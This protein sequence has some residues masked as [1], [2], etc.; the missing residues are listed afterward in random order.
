MNSRQKL[1]L[2]GEEIAGKFLI[3][4]GYTL[5]EKNFRTPYGEIDII[6]SNGSQLVFVEVKTRRSASYGAP[7]LA[8]DENKLRHLI[9]SAQHYIVEKN[10]MK[11]WQIDVIAIQINHSQDYEIKWFKNA[12]F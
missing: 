2:W 5:L 7:E 3:E 4:Q 6:V 10:V 1:G 8:V 12:T 9:E 11:D